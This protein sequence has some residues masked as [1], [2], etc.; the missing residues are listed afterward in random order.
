MSGCPEDVEHRHGPRGSRGPLTA[1]PYHRGSGSPRNVLGDRVDHSNDIR[2]RLGSRGT[3]SAA[4]IGG[5]GFTD[6]PLHTRLRGI[7]T[8]EFTRRR[9]LRLRPLVEEII[10]RRLD[11]F[12]ARRFAG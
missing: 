3:V 8:P 5:L 2:P 6:P 10:E 11:A 7:L 1:L 4:H 9:L 12:E